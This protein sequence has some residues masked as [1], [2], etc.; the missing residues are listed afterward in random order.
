MDRI[1]E[2]A[3]GDG[4]RWPSTSSDCQQTMLGGEVTSADK[5]ALR[6]RLRS[7]ADELDRSPEPH[8]YGVDPQQDRR[9]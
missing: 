8:E 2:E 9:L 3:R 1:E 4:L 7:L 6:D 5:Q